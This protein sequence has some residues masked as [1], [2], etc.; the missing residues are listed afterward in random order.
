MAMASREPRNCRFQFRS[1]LRFKRVSPLQL[2]CVAEVSASA[3]V[4]QASFQH[5]HAATLRHSELR[6][7]CAAA[8]LCIWRQS[9]VC[10]NASRRIQPS[11]GPVRDAVW[12]QRC[13]ISPG[14]WCAKS[15]PVCAAAAFASYGLFSTA[16]SAAVPSLVPEST[17]EPASLWSRGA[18]SWGSAISACPVRRPESECTPRSSV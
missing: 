11:A 3:S 15:D 18:W 2:L 6:G 9:P 14:V 12:T 17:N 5:V 16:V 8:I 4:W 1:F 7:A 10:T 13:S